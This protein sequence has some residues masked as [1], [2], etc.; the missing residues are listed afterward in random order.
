MGNNISKY[1]RK[2][3]P[4]A[5]KSIAE[6]IAQF[7]SIW[8]IVCFYTEFDRLILQPSLNIRSNPGRSNTTEFAGEPKRQR[9]LRRRRIRRAQP[10]HYFRVKILLSHRHSRPA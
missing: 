1:C 7:Q 5:R 6:R 8:K 4:M 3:P 9:H 10:P 2:E